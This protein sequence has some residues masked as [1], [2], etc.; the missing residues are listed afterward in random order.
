MAAIADLSDLVNRLTGGNSGTPETKFFH[1]TPRMNGAA[2]G[3][4]ALTG[5]PLSL[6]TFDGQPTAGAIPTTW[7]TC[8]NT[9]AGGLKQTDPG[10]G[11]QKWLF[12]LMATG[13]SL[14]TLLLYDRL[15]HNGNL[16]AT[17]TAAQ[18]FTGTPSRYTDGVGN[19]MWYE[20]YGTTTTVLGASTSAITVQ[21]DA[22]EGTN[23]VSKAIQ[24]GNTNFR[25]GANARLIPLQD[26]DTGI[27]AI[28]NVDLTVTTG[29]A[30]VWG[31]TL[32]HPLAYAGIGGAGVTGWRD[33]AT[34]MPG[35]PEILPGA[36]LS[37]L[38]YSG[39][40]NLIE[41]FGGVSFVES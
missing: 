15:G 29:T 37:F 31:M 23:H 34:G 7:A 8:D 1:K 41:L 27:T 25:E 14:G 20:I 5:R 6:W 30:G 35:L 2:P 11:R 40:T 24:I 39:S 12:Q 16:D 22:P 19:M 10:G 28:D 3:S 21:Y 18:T 32:A 26:G 36:C 38:S 9:T 17:N 33:F 4:L 13:S